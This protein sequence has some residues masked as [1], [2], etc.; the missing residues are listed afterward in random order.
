MLEW[1]TSIDEI[2]RRN[3]EIEEMVFKFSIGEYDTYPVQKA[4]YLKIKYLPI[5][6][7]ETC[8]LACEASDSTESGRH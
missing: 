2:T 4:G 6:A 5:M 1:R 3:Y 7:N 8:T